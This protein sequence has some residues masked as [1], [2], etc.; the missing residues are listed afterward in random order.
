LLVELFFIA[1]I[2]TS[3][4]GYLLI[5]KRRYG[6][7]K[8]QIPDKVV[9]AYLME[10]IAN[11]EGFKNQLFGEDFKIPVGAI[12][13]SMPRMEVAVSSANAEPSLVVGGASSAELAALKEQL[14]SSIAKQDDLTKTISQLAGEK[15]DLE[16]KLASAGAGAAASGDSKDLLD[17]ISK[18]E[19][20]LAEYEVIEDDLANLKRYQ[21]EV[22]QLRAQLEALKAG[23]TTIPAVEA[24]AAPVATPVAAP[25][26]AAPTPTPEQPIAEAAI[27]APET[28]SP[29]AAAEETVTETQAAEGFADMADK[30]DESLSPPVG[31]S[32]V[33][34]A[35]VAEAQTAAPASD[36]AAAEP[37][38]EKS[39]ADL[40]NEFERM[41]SS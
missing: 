32:V 8:N 2:T 21:Q 28:P 10:L 9:R 40:L 16:S 11:A 24:T 37:K 15:A 23:G 4:F 19:S 22:K 20:K 35:A 27:A 41:L 29:I 33:D 25:V 13:S 39:D 12:P 30:V 18:L 5:Q 38:S 7:A 14:N 1:L 17:K 3:Y 6:A 26:A 31:A 36:A 34:P